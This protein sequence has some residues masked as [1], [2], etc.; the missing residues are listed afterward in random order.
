M[1]SPDEPRLAPLRFADWDETTRKTLLKFLRRPEVYLSGAP[2]APP[3]PIV[4]EMFAR[5]L[6]LS[7]AWLPFTEMLASENAKLSPPHRELLI[8]RV[9]WR[10]RSGYE[11][12]QH[13]RMGVDAGLTPAQIEA[14][15]QGPSAAVWTPLERAM[16]AAVDEIIDDHGVGDATWR[17]L[18][19][20]LEPDEIFELLFLVGGYLCLAGVLN[21]IGLQSAMPP[22]HPGP[23]AEKGA[24]M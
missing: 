2:D 10:T 24:A 12:N 8:L 23:G 9:A 17:A 3:M 16:V 19:S 11:W 4:L 6:P 20:H 1:T 18:A 7:E 21:S 22:V 13:S 15:A 14:V 5:H